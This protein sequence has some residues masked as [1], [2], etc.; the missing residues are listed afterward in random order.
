MMVAKQ[1]VKTWGMY[2]WA[3][4][5]GISVKEANNNKRCE[6]E[7]NAI[8]NINISLQKQVN[9]EKITIYPRTVMG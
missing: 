9:H 6:A 2:R 5:G 3:V 1:W 7:S 4:K 8:G